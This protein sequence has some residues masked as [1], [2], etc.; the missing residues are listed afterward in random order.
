MTANARTLDNLIST[1]EET[2]CLRFNLV[3][4]TVYLL[5]APAKTFNI[6]SRFVSVFEANKNAEHSIF[7]RK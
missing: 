2:N 4:E 5:W 7:G 1:Q 6:H 3:F